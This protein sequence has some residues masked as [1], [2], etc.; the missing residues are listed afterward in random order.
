MAEQGAGEIKRTLERARLRV[1]ARA[2]L[3]AKARP[4]HERSPLVIEIVRFGDD[5]ESP[6]IVIPGERQSRETRD[7]ESRKKI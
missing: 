6:N 7:P 3:F 5:A 2:W 1:S 4:Y